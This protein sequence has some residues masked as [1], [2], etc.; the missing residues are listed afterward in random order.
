MSCI[1]CGSVSFVT[2]WG[3]R[4]AALLCSVV[5]IYMAYVARDFPAGGNQFPVFSCFAVIAI[6]VLMIVRTVL[7][8]AV[9]TEQFSLSF[10]GA[11]VFDEAKPLL[12]TAT[13][14]VYVML[15]FKLGYYTSSFLFLIIVS[16]A[17]GVR[18]LKT[19]ALTAVVTL[20][21]MYSFFELFLQARMPRGVLL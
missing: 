20:P 17:V 3:E 2:I 18:N 16:F 1:Y 10:S 11:D 5:A 15:I 13:V 8:P 6:S 12:L 4:T 9:F 7:S 21:L 19:I 14:V